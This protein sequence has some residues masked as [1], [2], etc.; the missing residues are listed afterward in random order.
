MYTLDGA[1]LHDPGNGWGV[2]LAGT[3]PKV[4]AGRADNGV[5][6][7]GRDGITAST[8]TRF[9]A[10][11]ETISMKIQGRDRAETE[12]RLERL[13]GLLATRHRLM[14]LAKTY[15]DDMTRVADVELLSEPSVEMPTST[16]ATVEFVLSIPAGVWR[17]PEPVVESVPFGDTVTVLS[18][19][20]ATMQNVWVRFV[21]PVTDPRVTD[22]ATG[23]ILGIDQAV[24][25]Y[26]V[27]NAASWAGATHSTDAW[28]I[29][30]GPPISGSQLVT[31]HGAGSALVLTP[32]I[33][34][35]G[36]QLR[37]E[38]AEAGTDARVE[39]RTHRAYH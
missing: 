23:R 31:N 22:V 14:A 2:L 5:V 16:Y 10:S 20:T 32:D 3:L 24:T 15:G 18:G 13:Y 33:L 12:T 4:L 39:V 25:N 29:S 35:G 19:A 17:S 38:G 8:G 36:V 37:A 28:D 9:E 34:A 21:G 26:A 7:P 1:P 6:I 30:F 11:S 27:I